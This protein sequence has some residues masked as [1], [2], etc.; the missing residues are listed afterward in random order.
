MSKDLIIK[1]GVVVEM[2]PA[3]TYKV[4]ADGKML[5]AYMAGKMRQN[6]ITV[7][8]GDKVKLEIS[9]KD[10]TRGRITRRL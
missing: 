10:E 7:L 6:R 8:V 3:T 5:I 9:P 2:L 4:E 1:E